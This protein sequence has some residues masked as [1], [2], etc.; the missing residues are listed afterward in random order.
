MTSNTFELTIRFKRLHS[1]F[2][3]FIDDLPCVL[4]YRR[5]L[6]LVGDFKTFKIILRIQSCFEVQLDLWN[7]ITNVTTMFEYDLDGILLSL[8]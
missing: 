4:K 2:I 3:L 5:S 7:E 8:M 6:S 1:L